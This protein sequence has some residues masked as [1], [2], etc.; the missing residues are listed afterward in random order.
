[1]PSRRRTRSIAVSEEAY[2]D[3]LIIQKKTGDTKTKIIDDSVREMLE[4][5]CYDLEAT[6]EAK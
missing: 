3:I 6:S 1:M 2:R 5:H 4:R